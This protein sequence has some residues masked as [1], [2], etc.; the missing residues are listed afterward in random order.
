MDKANQTLAQSLDP[1]KLNVGPV[2]QSSFTPGSLLL[3]QSWGSLIACRKATFTGSPWMLA[4]IEALFRESD[5]DEALCPGIHNLDLIVV[6]PLVPGNC[7]VALY[8]THI[9]LVIPRPSVFQAQLVFANLQ[10]VEA[11][12]QVAD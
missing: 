7:M 4:K 1:P 10:I 12:I 8:A 9:C 11:I 5:R 3:N 6:Y 2:G